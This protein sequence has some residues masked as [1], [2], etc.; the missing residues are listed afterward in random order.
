MKTPAVP[1]PQEDEGHPGVSANMM[2]KKN[3]HKKQKTSIGPS[4]TLV[5]PQ[6]N[7]V[8]CRIQHIWKE[9]SKSSQWKGTV[10]DQ[11]PVNPSLYLIKYDG[12]DCVYGLELHSDER[13]VGLEVLPDRVGEEPL[14]VHC[15]AS[16]SGR[17]SYL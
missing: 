4:K 5:Q 9:G 8:G 16:T 6:R 15:L 7:M 14:P 3:P 11:V 10:L 17:H 12:F 1:G 13:V 2:K